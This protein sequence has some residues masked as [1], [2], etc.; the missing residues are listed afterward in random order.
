MPAAYNSKFEVPYKCYQKE[1]TGDKKEPLMSKITGAENR[2]LQA[3][4]QN[5][6]GSVGTPKVGIRCI[7]RRMAL[8]KMEHRWRGDIRK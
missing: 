8:D 6:T 2:P 5:A 4:L 7:K 3:L 1:H